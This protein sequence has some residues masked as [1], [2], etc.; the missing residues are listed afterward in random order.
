MFLNQHLVLGPCEANYIITL[1][2]TSSIPECVKNRCSQGK[3]FFNGQCFAL[4]GDEGCREFSLFIGR[5]VLLVADPS[6]SG[7]TCA[8]EGTV[9]FSY[10]FKD[11]LNRSHRE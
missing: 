6:T 9:F 3:V 1:P 8:D 4:N 7:L 2:N 5:K 11:C 10:F